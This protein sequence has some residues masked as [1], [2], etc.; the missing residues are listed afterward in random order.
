MTPRLFL[1]VN[2]Q[3]WVFPFRTHLAFSVRGHVTLHFISQIG[4]AHIRHLSHEFYFVLLLTIE[5][6]VFLLMHTDTKPHAQFEKLW[7]IMDPGRRCHFSSSHVC[8]S[9]PLQ[10]T[11]YEWSAHSSQTAQRSARSLRGDGAVPEIAGGC[12]HS[13]L[14]EPG[15]S[16]VQSWSNPKYVQ[17]HT[18]SALRRQSPFKGHLNGGRASGNGKRGLQLAAFR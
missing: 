4:P 7:L 6:L 13:Y 1:D 10:C 14:H 16:S 8:C 12:I 3:R 11:D 9:L 15:A 5:A 17:S 2:E 18:G